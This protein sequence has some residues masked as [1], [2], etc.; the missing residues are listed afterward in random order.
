MSIPVEDFNAPSSAGDP[1]AGFVAFVENLIVPIYR[2]HLVRSGDPS[3]AEGRT[4]HT[5]QMARARLSTPDRPAIPDETWLWGLALSIHSDAP[6]PTPVVKTFEPSGFTEPEPEALR[7]QHALIPQVALAFERLPARQAEIL[8]LRL[9]AGLTDDQAAEAM[10]RSAAST[11]K[12]YRQGLRRLVEI[13][14][15]ERVEDLESDLLQL[16]TELLGLVERI[17]PD[18]RFLT[19][20]GETV[21]RPAPP[22]PVAAAHGR[23]LSL[24][25]G[26]SLRRYAWI[27]AVIAG[28]IL[29][30][31]NIW[32]AP[33]VG[34][35]K[36]APDPAPSPE[37]SR[38]PIPVTSGYLEPASPAACQEIQQAVDQALHQPTFLL[39]DE[40]FI[41]PTV[42][43]DDRNG[44]GC[45]IRATGSGEEF[46]SIDQTI[47]TIIPV[48]IGHGYQLDGQFGSIAAC[49]TCFQFPN[50]WFG[51]GLLFNKSDGRAILSVG[52]RPA[53]PQLCPT[54]NSKQGCS[55]PLSAQDF[56]LRLNLA[57]DP[58][59]SA[60]MAFFQLWQVGNVGAIDF[61][62]DNLR[63]RLTNLAELDTLV[64]IQQSQLTHAQ[65]TWRIRQTS[66]QAVQLSVNIRSLIP[67][68]ASSASLAA[69]FSRLSVSMVADQGPWRIENIWRTDTF[70]RARDSAF[71]ADP[72][73]R[74]LAL[75]TLDGSA[76]ALTEPNFF[77]P[78]RLPD[79]IPHA[80]QVHL[81]PDGM[82]LAISKPV[83]APGNPDLSPIPGGVWLISTGGS[84]ARQINPRPLH[85]AWAPNSHQIAYISPRDAQ[86]I[87][88]Y[89]V[90]TGGNSI[91]TRTW[92]AI[93]SMAWSPNGAQLAVTYP[94]PVKS[95]GQATPNGI[96]LA[97]IDA[98]TGHEDILV[99]FPHL[100]LGHP[101]DPDLELS[102][103]ASGDEVWLLPARTA[104]DIATQAVMP[105]VP[106]YQAAISF[107]LPPAPQGPAAFLTQ[108]A[109]DGALVANSFNEGYQGSPEWVA[110]HSIAPNQTDNPPA[111]VF[112]RIGTVAAL[113]WTD[114]SQNLIVAGGVDTLQPIWRMDPVT[115][116]TQVLAQS[117]YF[118]GL[119]SSLQ[120]QSLHLAPQAQATPLID[121]SSYEGLVTVDMPAFHFNLQVPAWWRV[122][123]P[124]IDGD[125]AQISSVAFFGQAGVT[126]IHRDQLLVQISQSPQAE[127]IGT[128]L[129]SLPPAAGAGQGPAWETIQVGG[130]TAYRLT[131]PTQPGGPMV[132]QIPQ[133][134]QVTIIT[135]Y[136]FTSDFDPL[137]EQILKSLTFY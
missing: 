37:F 109:P 110:I 97:V 65:I 54:P 117:A 7:L 91:L 3:R 132:I 102:W 44:S 93:R 92:G 106:S 119:R 33:A 25:N 40:P 68:S 59:R 69:Q 96:E 114:D 5:V 122:T 28:M 39:L 47:Q 104:V 16:E 26:E 105:L 6:A 84:G 34:V 77:A 76:V 70:Q 32:S 115:G 48:L 135:K 95:L 22:T 29:I 89:D 90:T 56:T 98:S 75:S 52:W 111:P 72:Q 99:D 113:A 42:V 57:S 81:S 125:P 101:L 55:L 17:H 49:P 129:Q 85:L 23:R 35:S 45:E 38:K 137:F 36:R 4:A 127:P 124:E 112:K 100:D 103:T 62:T 41:D 63:S 31:V 24:P 123:Q 130:R 30:A 1:P 21:R 80:P 94:M 13:L 10:R 2:Y 60:L 133:S 131:H 73:G 11:A 128:Q 53:D 20:L 43:G 12:E 27:P 15:P 83:L 87:Y 50:D 58:A 18:P 9:F 88:L 74:I 116:Q 19:S 136:P 66:I 79:N 51:K 46:Q 108:L 61:L 120:S 107:F 64:G 126:S 121:R 118:L 67:G 86:A 8:A 14:S 134:G 71:I 78:P 82:W